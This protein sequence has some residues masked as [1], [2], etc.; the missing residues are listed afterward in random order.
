MFAF[1]ESS[2]PGNLNAKHLISPCIAQDTKAPQTASLKF[3]PLWQESGDSPK[4]KKK[5]LMSS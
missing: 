1:G 3:F 5:N 2:I 4:G